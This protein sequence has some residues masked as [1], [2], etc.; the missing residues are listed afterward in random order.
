MLSL[1]FALSSPALA[2][3]KCESNGKISY[4][5]EPCGNG[6]ASKFEA[7]P[8]DSA[9]SRDIASARQRAA[10]EKNELKRLESERQRLEAQEDK[11]NQKLARAN[12]SKKKKCAELAL[13]QKWAEEDASAASG[14][15]AQ[16]IKRTA[17]RKAEKFQLECG[18]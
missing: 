17:R 13:Q 5:D 8:P 6:K 4:S 14:K 3:N 2:I 10:R 11:E 1:L 9:M 18:K 12:A 16:K 7:P 15:S